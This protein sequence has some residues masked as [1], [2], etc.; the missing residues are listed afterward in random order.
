MSIH[1]VDALDDIPDTLCLEPLDV[2]EAAGL[3]ALLL[4]L[5][6]NHRGLDNVRNQ[7]GAFLADRDPEAW[8]L[9]YADV[10]A[11]IE[12]KVRPNPWE[13]TPAMRA[14]LDT[15]GYKI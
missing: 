3:Y 2:L 9:F 10:D 13:I 6:I 15:K 14:L 12:I 8:A 7:I 5:H 11:A 4:Q 1:D